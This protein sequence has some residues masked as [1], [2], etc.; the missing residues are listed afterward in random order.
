MVALISAYSAQ[1]KRRVE[2]QNSALKLT[3]LLGDLAQIWPHIS[4]PQ[5]ILLSSPWITFFVFLFTW[6]LWEFF[7]ICHF[8]WLLNW[9]YWLLFC[10]AL[11][12]ETFLSLDLFHGRLRFCCISLIIREMQ[13]KT[14]LRFH[15]TP[16][17]MSK[18]KNSGD[19][20][21]FH[22]FYV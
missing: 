12:I 13:I 5:F 3:W 22:Y 19:S 16:V 20:R 9:P 6:I 10:C 2:L 7:A 11:S 18:I 1:Y 8:Y 15:L 17:R 4:G 21:C 14:T